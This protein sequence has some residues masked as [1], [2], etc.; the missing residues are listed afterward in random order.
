[1]T[2][3]Q[4]PETKLEV[5]QVRADM[6]VLVGDVRT[7][8]DFARDYSDADL[9]SKTFPWQEVMLK[10]IDDLGL[11]FGCDLRS[12]RC[13]GDKTGANPFYRE[14]EWEPAEVVV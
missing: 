8:R 3:E 5:F 13:H 12:V 10:I 11:P 2:F 9:D 7:F 4:F 14:V 1:M 6:M